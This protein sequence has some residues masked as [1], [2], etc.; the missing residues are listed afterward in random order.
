M[1]QNG[2]LELSVAMT[3]K[4]ERGKWREGRAYRSTTAQSLYLTKRVPPTGEALLDYRP[5]L[6]AP[7]SERLAFLDSRELLFPNRLAT[8]S[9]P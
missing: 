6:P 4:W 9:F 5:P 3:F 8:Y 1:Y 7:N 2:T